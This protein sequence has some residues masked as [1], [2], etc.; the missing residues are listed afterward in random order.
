MKRCLTSWLS[1]MMVAFA[2]FA[3]AL[4]PMAATPATADARF[5][6]FVQSLWPQAHKAGVSR[7][8]FEAAFRGVTPD[9]EVIERA[10]NQAEFKT[11][12]WDYIDQRVS[13]A[14]IENGRAMLR[15]H[16]ARV[17]AIEKRYGVP[18]T[19]LLAV[20]GMETNYGSHMGDKYVI[21]SLATLAYT[22]RRQKFGRQQLIAAL[23]ILQR[24]DIPPSHMSGSW[25]GAMGYTQFIPTTYNAYAVDWTGDGS[26]DIWRSVADALASTG[27]YLHKS[28]WKPGLPWGWEV[29]L[30]R[31]FNT[32]S[33]G[34]KA[35]IG[36]W[37]KRGLKLADGSTF[38][39]GSTVPAT[40]LMPAGARGPAFLVT[41]NFRAILRY[42][43]SN[44]YALAV[45]HLADRIAGGGPIIGAWP[46]PANA[47]SVRER[48][49]LQVLLTA[50]GYDTG[51]VDGNVGPQTKAA[52]ERA[53]RDAGLTADG[54]PSSRLLKHLKQDG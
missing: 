23:K 46:R 19:V 8:T 9:P 18:S 47:L 42:N 49:E 22:G 54:E 50:R 25:A 7:A 14:R 15:E 33:A 3:C 38:K 24:G 43:N 48:M 4:G 30:P 35:T 29:Q 11:P 34:A 26:R 53:Q 40:L 20:W 17:A 44:A 10:E 41:Q 21:R 2:T 31:G 12:V 28:G 52:V 51:G 32:K 27:N 6:R 45:G 5:D 16:A 13:D 39:P 1:A 37:A 36:T